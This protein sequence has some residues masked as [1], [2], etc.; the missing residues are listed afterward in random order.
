[1]DIYV[2]GSVVESLSYNSSGTWTGLHSGDE[3][4]AELNVSSCTE[5][6]S[7]TANAYTLGI[8]VDASCGA[9]VT[10]LTTTTYT[11]NSGD[12]GNTIILQGFASCDSGCL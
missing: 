7:T 8:I 10:G 2:N 12:L 3:I 1:M 11:V 5:V 9:A 6:G 4:Y